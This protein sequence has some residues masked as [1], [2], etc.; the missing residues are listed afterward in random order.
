MKRMGWRMQTSTMK[1]NDCSKSRLGED[2]KNMSSLLLILLL[3]EFLVFVVKIQLIDEAKA[4]LNLSQYPGSHCV[5]SFHL[6][7][8]CCKQPVFIV[9]AHDATDQRAEIE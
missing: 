7:C 3:E 5:R 6:V 9:C 8:T 2:K 4:K 1:R